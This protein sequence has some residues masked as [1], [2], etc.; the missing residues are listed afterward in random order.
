[1]SDHESVSPATREQPAPAPPPGGEDTPPIWDGVLRHLGECDW[2]DGPTLARVAEDVKARDALGRQRYGQP[3]HHANGRD[4][5]TDAYQELID[6]V[7]YLGCADAQWW[8]A[9]AL[10]R[11]I[12]NDLYWTALRTAVRLREAIDR[13][14]SGEWGPRAG[15][16]GGDGQ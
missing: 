11:G 7:G 13:R 10:G 14:D 15:T 4:H 5:L 1:M 2:C 16:K 6:A 12:V 9:K 3:L 8:G